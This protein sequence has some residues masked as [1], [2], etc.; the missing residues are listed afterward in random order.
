MTF[1]QQREIMVE[2]HLVRRGIQ[3]P[4]VLNALRSVPREAFVSAAM[5]EFAYS[6]TP[7]PIE[8]GQ[9]I[10]QPYIVAV[11]AEALGLHGKERVLE[12]GTGSGY[13]AAVLSL[14]AKEVF[15][16]ERHQSLAATARRRLDEHGFTNVHV[17][18]GDGTLGL[19]DHAPYDAIAVAAGAP[20]LPP[21]LLE[22]LAIG[23]RLVI[24]VGDSSQTL[25]RITRTGEKEYEREELAAV[26]FV[27]LIGAAGWQDRSNLREP[28]SKHAPHPN[29]ERSLRHLVREC[30]EPIAAI[31]SAPVGSLLEQTQSAT[32]V[33]LGES[34]HGTSEFYRMRARITQELILRH[35]FNFVAIEADWPDAARV[36]AHVLGRMPQSPLDFTPFARFPTWM[37]RNRETRDFITWLQQYNTDQATSEQRVGFHGLDIYSMFTSVAAVL[38]YLDAVDPDAAKV[39]RLR[40]GTLTPWQRDPAAYGRAVLSGRYESSETMVIAMLSDLLT[41]RLDYAMADGERFFDAAQ[42]AH[43]VASAEA[44]YRAMYYGSTESWNLRDQHMFDTL[45]RLLDFYGP[46]TRAVVWEHNSHVGDARA[47]EMGARGELNL[48]QLCREHLGERAYNVGFGTDHGTVAA[49]RGWDQPMRHMQVRR[50]EENSYEHLF[51][52]SGLPAFIMHLRVPARPEL[53]A[54]LRAPRLERAIGVVYRPE[55]ELASHYFRASLPRQFDSYVWFD[56]S[57]AVKALPGADARHFPF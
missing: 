27:P 6:D 51:H 48:G 55:N 45:Q 40:Y 1:A 50:S 54:E 20:S 36:D 24:P 11:T 25:V 13:A 3:D 17:Q 16:I 52:A 42:N 53:S 32:V 2:H 18:W 33:L 23:G 56:E 47:T 34:T 12:V 10:S 38:T 4:T 21:A 44:Y 9:T 26:H 57:G 28:S 35:G 29:P 43:V 14:L 19:P 31:D 49:A 37:W 39:A 46:G 7:L 41:R 22:Q 15:T 8:E 5:V 30:A